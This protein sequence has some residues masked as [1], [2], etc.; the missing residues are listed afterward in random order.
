LCSLK[1][2][3]C[4]TRRNRP[5][6]GKI[7]AGDADILASL[8]NARR[9]LGRRAL[10]ARPSLETAG[11]RTERLA[12]EENSDRKMAGSQSGGCLLNANRPKSQSGNGRTGMQ[13]KNYPQRE[14]RVV[15]S[16]KQN[17]LCGPREGSLLLGHDDRGL[18]CRLPQKNISAKRKW[19]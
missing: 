7:V 13:K 2:F 9:G 12:P 5:R 17:K 16:S 18:E 3:S 14:L 8:A 6:A 1:G 10:S 4:K 11:H 19:A 15:A